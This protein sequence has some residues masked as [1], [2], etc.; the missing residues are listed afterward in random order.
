VKAHYA[1]TPRTKGEKAGISPADSARIY[2]E[3]FGRIGKLRS[4]IDAA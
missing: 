1:C 3:S 2:A 4:I